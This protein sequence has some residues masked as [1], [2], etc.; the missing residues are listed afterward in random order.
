MTITSVQQVISIDDKQ[1]VRMMIY[2]DGAI[3][4]CTLAAA[5]QRS[6]GGKKLIQQTQ[7]TSAPMKVSTA[8]GSSVDNCVATTI[9]TYTFES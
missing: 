1:T 4:S 2:I 6:S 3:Q 9:V 8:M 7:T 5:L